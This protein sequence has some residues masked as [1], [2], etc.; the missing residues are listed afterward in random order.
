MSNL[1]ILS[2]IEETKSL[3]IST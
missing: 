3:N 2:V 1:S